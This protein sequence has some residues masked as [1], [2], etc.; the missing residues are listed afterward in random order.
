MDRFHSCFSIYMAFLFEHVTDNK[1]NL[2]K[3]YQQ[4]NFLQLIFLVSASEVL[5]NITKRHKRLNN[6]HF[7][8]LQQE[9]LIGLTRVQVFYPD[10]TVEYGRSS[11][12]VYSL[13][14]L[15]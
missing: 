2:G 4:K 15:L 12:I 7:S 1:K 8:L 13:K 14:A 5:L 6:L 11:A 10:A 3:W 9:K